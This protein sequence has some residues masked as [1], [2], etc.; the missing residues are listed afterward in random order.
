MVTNY[1]VIKNLTIDEMADLFA[2]LRLE[3]AIPLLKDVGFTEEQLD[4]LK[5]AVT[6]IMKSF[7]KSEVKKE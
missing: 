5:I 4:N 6:A 1:K 7:L 2:T 3:I